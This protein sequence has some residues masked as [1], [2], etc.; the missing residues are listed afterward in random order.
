MNIFSSYKQSRLV[1]YISLYGCVAER[2]RFPEKALDLL[3]IYFGSQFWLIT[4]FN[5]TADTQKNNCEVKTAKQF[6]MLIKNCEE[7]QKVLWGI[8]N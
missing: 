4:E 5:H 6:S 2:G 3:A 1:K 8:F 7:F